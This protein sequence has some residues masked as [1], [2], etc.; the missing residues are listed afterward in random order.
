MRYVMM[1]FVGS[2]HAEAWEAA[3]PEDR[4]AEVDRTITWF[5]TNATH[6]VGGEE[7]GRPHAA[8]TI[9]K[10]GV[11]D[12]P[13]IE[14]KELLGGFIVLDVRDEAAA[15]AIAGGWPGLDWPGDAVELRPTGDAQAEVADPA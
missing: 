15:L 10:A 12:G 9:R 13:F 1:T 3:T 4:Q 8:R 6:I 5:R 14:T 2:E 7:L 11:T